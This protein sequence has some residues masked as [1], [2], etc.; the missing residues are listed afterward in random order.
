MVI[1]PFEPGLYVFV[2]LTIASLNFKEA[3]ELLLAK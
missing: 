3:L 1:D 2:P